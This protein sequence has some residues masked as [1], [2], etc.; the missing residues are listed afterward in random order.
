MKKLLRRFLMPGMI[1]QSRLGFL[2]KAVPGI[3]ALMSLT[4]LAFWE[5]FAPATADVPRW[6]WLSASAFAVLAIYL[7]WA[8][9]ADLFGRLAKAENAMRSMLEGNLGERASHHGGDELAALSRRINEII[10]GTGSTLA[11]VVSASRGVTDAGDAMAMAAQALAI[12]TEDQTNVI[13]ETTQA[14][15]DVLQS[16]RRTSDMANNVDQVSQNLCLQADSSNE[17][18]QQAVEAMTRIKHSTGMM[19]ESLTIIDGLT[20]QTNILA[21]NA[22]IEAARAGQAG[23]GFAVVAGE[24]RAL[25][26]RTSDAADEI[27]RIIATANKE[28]GN[29]E[30]AVRSVKT[31]ID[32]VTVG[33][34]DV[35]GQMRDVSGNNLVQSAAITLVSQGLERLAGITESNNQL[36]VQSVGSS[37]GLRM[38]AEEL[39]ALISRMSRDG[40][41]NEVPRAAAASSVEFMLDDDAATS[42]TPSA[43]PASTGVEFF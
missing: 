18:V 13:R 8:G 32:E 15:D 43:A 22:A 41:A 2:G 7:N 28:V 39:H 27:K 17:V 10:D 25:A 30:T 23:R 6:L 38:S 40:S 4:A 5:S 33:F 1:F 12:Q 34:R 26:K 29:G 42:T 24:V 31:V 19:V 3:V 16:V 21:L 35:S 9:L 36:V 37:E 20:F 11:Q 14:V